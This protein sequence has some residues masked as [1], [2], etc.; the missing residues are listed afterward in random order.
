MSQNI[1]NSLAKAKLQ[2][3]VGKLY[4]HYKI[5]QKYYRL[6]NLAINEADHK[7]M[8]VYTSCDHDEI[9]WI[10]PLD[11]WLETLDGVPRFSLID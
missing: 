3:K 10:R 4:S 1:I 6:N 2:V 11:S 9:T 5:P 7:V 8:V